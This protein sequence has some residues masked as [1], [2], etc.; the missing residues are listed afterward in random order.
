MEVLIPSAGS[1]AVVVRLTTLDGDPIADID[2]TRRISPV[3]LRGKLFG[4]DDLD[5]LRA[6]VRAMR[7]IREND[8]LRP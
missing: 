5:A 7:D 4:R 3:V 1:L 2:N 6:A 8:W